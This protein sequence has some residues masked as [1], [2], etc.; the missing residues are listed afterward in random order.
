MPDFSS[1]TQAALL[2]SLTNEARNA[3]PSGIIDM[4]DYA[5]GREGVIPL[6]VGEGSLPTP[7][8]ICD[9]AM[10]SLKDGETFYTYQ[11]GIPPLRA[12]LA[13]YHEQLYGRPFSPERFFVTGSGMQAIQIA[14]RMVAGPG[15][16]VIVP[17][18][19]WPNIMAAT[20]IG[21]AKTV[22]VPLDFSPDGWKLNLDRLFSSCSPAC[23]ALFINSP[24]NPTGWTASL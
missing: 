4:I 2:S 14:A 13:R 17:T 3:P 6:W 22:E 23:R 16:E 1:P 21:G 15:N 18:P 12:A 10:A 11:R 8:F 7:D 24:A 19:A 9:A 5:R 20:E